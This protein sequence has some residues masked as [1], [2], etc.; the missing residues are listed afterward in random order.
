[1]TVPSAR[2]SSAE[3]FLA[4]ISSQQK[5]WKPSSTSFIDQC[6]FPDPDMPISERRIAVKS[7]L[8]GITSVKNPDPK[9][10]VFGRPLGTSIVFPHFGRS[11]GVMEFMKSQTPSTKFR[12]FRCQVSG[13]RELKRKL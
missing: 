2:V 13:V 11:A 6:D 5:R 7:G 10:P 8:D 12:G 4:I 3:R 9:D 1:M